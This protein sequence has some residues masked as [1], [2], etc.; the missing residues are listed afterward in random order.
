[1]SKIVARVQLLIL[2]WYPFTS[3]L[4]VIYT[5][6]ALAGSYGASLKVTIPFESSTVYVEGSCNTGT[7]VSSFTIY[8]SLTK[9]ISL[10]SKWYSVEVP[11]P[12]K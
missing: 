12:Q 1:M 7:P 5:L 4:Y 8:T 9:S 2:S 10:L 6:S 11:S 3:F